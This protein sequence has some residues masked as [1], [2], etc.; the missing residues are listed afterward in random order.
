MSLTTTTANYIDNSRLELIEGMLKCNNGATYISDELQNTFLELVKQNPEIGALKTWSKLFKF[1]L[2]PGSSVAFLPDDFFYS[3]LNPTTKKFNWY[4]NFENI[5]AF[6]LQKK[7]TNYCFHKNVFL[8]VPFLQQHT[9]TSCK[10]I[11]VLCNTEGFLKLFLD[12]Y[13]KKLNAIN[14][15]STSPLNLLSNSITNF[16]KSC[17]IF[18]NHPNFY[19]NSQNC[20]FLQPFTDANQS[21]F[22]LSGNLIIEQGIHTYHCLS[23]IG[24]QV[25]EF[26]V[27]PDYKEVLNITLFRDKITINSLLRFELKST[28]KLAYLLNVTAK[29]EDFSSDNVSLISHWCPTFKESSYPIRNFSEKIIQQLL[30]FFNFNKVQQPF[31]HATPEVHE[32]FSI[33]EELFSDKELKSEFVSLKNLASRNGS[34]IKGSDL[35]KYLI[36]IDDKIKYFGCKV[37]YKPYTSSSGVVRT[38]KPFDKVLDLIDID[39]SNKSSGDKIIINNTR[40]IRDKCYLAILSNYFGRAFM[41]ARIENSKFNRHK[42]NNNMESIKTIIKEFM[43]SLSRLPSTDSI[44]YKLVSYETDF[45]NFMQGFN[46]IENSH[47]SILSYELPKNANERTFLVLKPSCFAFGMFEMWWEF[48]NRNNDNIILDM[49]TALPSLSDDQI[50]KLYNNS[51]NR[52]WGTH[53]WQY[54]KSGPSIFLEVSTSSLRILRQDM[55]DYRQATKIIWTKNAVHCASDRHESLSNLN[56]FFDRRYLTLEA[57]VTK[58]EIQNRLEENLKNNLKRALDNTEWGGESEPSTSK[59]LREELYDLLN[60]T[61]LSADTFSFTDAN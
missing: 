52:E 38:H 50:S 2:V 28:D 53:W 46:F 34:G 11:E 47:P 10:T 15:K 39:L 24:D 21:D 20:L 31:L 1:Q 61:E 4:F 27:Y 37:V 25:Y 5:L 26:S 58:S 35:V 14:N 8:T 12:A 22:Y 42:L 17:L 60:S 43:N 29:F 55:L 32:F 9:H 3:V 41:Y 30:K 16:N 18:C 59:Q 33:R 44:K 51:Q 54:L 56:D 36:K 48:F 19:K 13:H 7:Y 23:N 57:L 49:K 40:I 45:L 6:H